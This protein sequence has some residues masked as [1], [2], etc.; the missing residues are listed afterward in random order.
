M[1]VCLICVEI[2]AWGKYGGYGRATRMLGRELSKH[3][4]EVFAVVPL[5]KNQNEVEMLDGI[6]VL[7]FPI[8][9]PWKAIK[10]IQ[11]CQADIYHSQE[12]SL[13]TYLALKAM[14]DKKHMITFRDPKTLHDWFIELCYP[15]ISR[16]RKFLSSFYDDN[17]LI[18]NSF[19]KVD[20]L[21]CCV[22]CAGER[23]RRIY[24]LK[25][26]P[27]FLPSPIDVPDRKMFKS[28]QPAVCFVGRWDR[29]KK[30]EEFFN[31]AEK[32]PKVTFIA[33]GKSHDE[34]RDNYLRQKYGNLSNLEI[35]GW[36]DQFSTDK[37]SKLLEKSWILVNPAPREGLPTSYLE[38]L[39]HRCAILSAV[40]PD[41]LAEK[42]GYHVKDNDFCEG[43]N[44]LLESDNW[45]EKG[46]RGYKYVGEN[47]ELDK[48]VKKHISVY[49]N[50]LK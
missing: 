7:G 24:S 9:K 32:F 50:I 40:N 37:L 31:M 15:S 8:A 2:F 27:S 1:K 14:P 36:I 29:R 26:E 10:L 34:K 33:A 44:R 11:K 18:R 43:L 39:A 38:A 22:P 49:E 25:S 17:F 12:P 47:Y 5:R 41:G 19:K 28:S 23:A 3:G 30:P 35:V 20:G 46:E 42:F 6:K 16:T 21:F 13:T 4:L 48:T 45:K